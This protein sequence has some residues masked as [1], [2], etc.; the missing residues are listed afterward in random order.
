[1]RGRGGGD[2]QVGPANTCHWINVGSMLGR[3]RR[4][5]ANIDPPL[6]QYLVFAGGNMQKERTYGNGHVEYLVYLINLNSRCE[7]NCSYFVHKV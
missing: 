4:R 1:M 3:R 2:S 6:I 5:R 7:I